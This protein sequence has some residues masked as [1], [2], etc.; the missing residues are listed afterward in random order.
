MAH[1][2]E[3]LIWRRYEQHEPNLFKKLYIAEQRRK[4]ERF[5]RRT[6]EQVQRVI[7]VSNEDAALMRSEFGASRVD[8]VE[9]GVDLDYFHPDKRRRRP[10]TVLFLGSL[11]WRPNLDAVDILLSS[12]MPR[13]RSKLPGATLQVVGRKPPAMLQ[14]RIRGIP[15][16]ELHADVDD[17][18]PFLWEAT[19]MA[20]PLRIGGGSRLKILEALATETP[21]VS[22]RVGAEGLALEHGREIT[23]VEDPF[24]M[25]DSL[26]AAMDRPA[27]LVEHARAGRGKVTSRYGWDALANRLHDVW[28]A[29]S[30]EK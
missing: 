15:W 11:D 22:T 25:A 26:V 1:N 24:Q 10:Q 13:V 14:D 12:I 18:R 29:C 23:L 30:N 17:V 4:F 16:A 28:S 3:S 20:V 9:N 7:A 21:V 6:F 19:L 5:E 27:A 2:V 8:V